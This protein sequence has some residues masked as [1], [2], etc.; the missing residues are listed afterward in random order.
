MEEERER[1]KKGEKE[2]KGTEGRNMSDL[3]GSACSTNV[4][5]QAVVLREF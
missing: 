3:Q 4:A 1:I 2:K 5:T